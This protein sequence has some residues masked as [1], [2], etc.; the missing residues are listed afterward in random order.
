MAR[1]AVTNGASVALAVARKPANKR[2]G[3]RPPVL[4]RDMVLNAAIELGKSNPEAP[5]SISAIA[6]SLKVTPMALYTYFGN[7]DELMQALSARLLEGLQIQIPDEATPLERIMTWAYAVRQ[8]CLD[9]PQL[10]ALLVWEGGRSSA[11]WLNRSSPLFAAVEA[12]GFEGEALGR[13]MLWLWDA[14]MS[15]IRLELYLRQSDSPEQEP[16]A[17]LDPEVR[18]GVR[19]VQLAAEGDK[20]H[21]RHFAFSMEQV[22]T[23][24]AAL[25]ARSS[26]A[27]FKISQVG[28]Q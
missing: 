14:I 19:M 6:R 11:A 12:L 8:Y 10:I 28:K 25:A 23:A 1:N 5:V 9:H 2:K 24:I 18:E 27:D 13:A 17:A 7:R 16:E 22:A 15:T 3:G 20:N 26:L 21:D 4:S